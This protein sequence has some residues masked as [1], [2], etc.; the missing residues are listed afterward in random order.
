MI[1]FL[2]KLLGEMTNVIQP[3]L[4][5][6]EFSVVLFAIVMAAGLIAGL[7][8][9]GMTTVVFLVRQLPTDEE[10]SRKN[11]FQISSLFSLGA[12][13]SLILVGIGAA[14]LGK[15]MV[16]YSLARYFPIITLLIGLQMVGI[17]KWR[18]FPKFKPSNWEGKSNVFLLGMPFGVVT[19]PCTAPII[20]TILSLVA[21]NGDLLFGLLTLLTFA[22]GRSIPLIAAT[23]Y[24]EVLLRYLKPQRKWFHILNTSLGMM[25]IIGSIYFLTWGQKYFGT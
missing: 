3:Y 13:L 14:Y 24:S 12:I 11:G 7:S 10:S 19:P 20:V 21:A 9:F 17:W 4:Y 22:V 18:L 5:G 8:P 2:F 1:D 25:I 15:I 16:N 6:Q 23:T